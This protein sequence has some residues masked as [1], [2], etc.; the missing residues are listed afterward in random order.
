MQQCT[1]RFKKVDVFEYPVTPDEMS[2]TVSRQI[3]VNSV[4]GIQQAPKPKS[5]SN[6]N[7]NLFDMFDE[8]QDFNP[9]GH[10]QSMVS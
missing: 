2:L 8:D 7:M 5:R 4:L 10:E 6:S 3:S 1:P 9:Q